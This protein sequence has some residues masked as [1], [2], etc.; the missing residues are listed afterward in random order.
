MRLRLRAGV[1]G[2]DTSLMASYAD[3]AGFHYM[4]GDFIG[5]WAEVP[6]N[7]LRFTRADLR[8]RIVAD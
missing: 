1:E 5:T 6:E 2:V 4:A 7:A 3:G 8:A